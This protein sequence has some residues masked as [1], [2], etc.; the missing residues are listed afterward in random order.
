MG[1]PPTRASAFQPRQAIREQIDDALAHPGGT[2]GVVLTQVLSGGGGYG[3]TQLAAS[4][5]HT[6]TSEAGTQLV[7]WAT[8]A[9]EQALITTY[10]QAALAVQAPGATG[11]NPENDAVAFLRWLTTTDRSWLVVLDN[12]T[13]PAHVQRWWPQGPAGWALATTRLKDDARLTGGGRTRITVDVYAPGEALAYLHQRLTAD[14]HHLYDEQSAKDVITE[15]GRLPLAL[16]FAA[17]YM[18][19]Q[20]ATCAEYLHHLTSQQL[21]GALPEWA[22]AE[23]YGRPVAAALLL[24][25]HAAIDAGPNRIVE[26]AL[27]LTALLDPDGHPLELWTTQP[28][29]DL[30]TVFRG[31]DGAPVSEQEARDAVT[32]LHRYGLIDRNRGNGHTA[33]RIHA[34]T[35]RAVR[36]STPATAQPDLATTAADAL[37]TIWPEVDEPHRDL[38]TVLRTNTDT[39]NTHD[40]THLW[41][42]DHGGHPVLF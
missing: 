10:A 31:P 23:N 39:L 25:L 38:A 15:L 18:I 16:G 2:G 27:Q 12:I 29:R 17:A 1:Q 9:E 19:Q 34:L 28:I 41:S 36:E 24:N 5:A 22:D 30:L 37:L 40:Q 26:P 4:Y 42:Q 7:V 33:V 14:H 35:A 32:V 3:K 6:A 8:A 13:D 21:P 20:D 11:E